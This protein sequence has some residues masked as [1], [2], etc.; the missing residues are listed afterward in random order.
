MYIKYTHPPTKVY[1]IIIG[2]FKSL[3]VDEIGTTNFNKA[4]T[5]TI[6]TVPHKIF[7]NCFAVSSYLT[8]HFLFNVIKHITSDTP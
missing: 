1:R 7:I 3:V 6:N 8:P 5:K 4:K 2:I